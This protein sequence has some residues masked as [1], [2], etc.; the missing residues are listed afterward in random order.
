MTQAEMKMRI[1]SVKQTQMRLR[2]V[3]LGIKA[4]LGDKWDEGSQNVSRYLAE[5][6]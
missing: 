1:R 2:Y 3:W 6:D 4:P 5:F